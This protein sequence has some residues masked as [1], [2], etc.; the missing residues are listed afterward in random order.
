MATLPSGETAIFAPGTLGYEWN[1]CPDNGFQPP[2]LMRLSSATVDNVS[3][4]QD[5]GSTYPTDQATHH[6][7]LYRHSG[8]AL[9]FSAG[10]VQWSWGLEKRGHMMAPAAFPADV[11]MQQAT[12][13]LFADM[14]TQPASLQAGLTSREPFKRCT[15]PTSTIQ[16]PLAGATIRR[17]SGS[18][19]W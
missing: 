14:E 12:V 11:R 2:G 5:Y 1:E 13:N 19:H 3:R 9:V 15:A 6:L 17:V 4:L 7:T 10:T 16:S 8:G 18:H